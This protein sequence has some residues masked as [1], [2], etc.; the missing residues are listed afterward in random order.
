MK[1]SDK[2]WLLL[3][4]KAMLMFVVM[5]WC[6]GSTPVHRVRDG[7]IW[8]SWMGQ[9]SYGITMRILHWNNLH[10]THPAHRIQDPR[11]G[12]LGLVSRF[13][14]LNSPQSLHLSSS[15]SLLHFDGSLLT[16]ELTYKARNHNTLFILLQLCYY[17]TYLHKAFTHHLR[18]KRIRNPK[19]H[20][21]KPESQYITSRSVPE[22]GD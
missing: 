17:L 22:T 19:S 6:D 4:T 10:N 13:K 14:Y 5:S 1:S 12:F 16:V 2:Q 9:T 7:I 20:I 11:V 21:L 15:F 18:C 3:M 8:L